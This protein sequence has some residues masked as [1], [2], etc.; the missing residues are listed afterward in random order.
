VKKLLRQAATAIAAL[1]VALCAA[2]DPSEG[3]APFPVLDAHVD[4][5]GRLLNRGDS[6]A[7]PDAGGQVDIPKWRTGGVNIVWVAIWVDPRRYPGEAAYEKANA[8]IDALEQDVRAH[9]KD[10]EL[11]RTAAQCQEAARRGKIALLLGLEGG[12]PLMSSP[13]V[14]DYFW[15]RGIRRVTL[16]WRGDLPW[17]GSSQNWDQSAVRRP[18]GLSELGEQLV[19]QMN[20]R[21]IVVDLSHT[22]ELTAR[23]AI[24]VSQ[25]PVIFSHSNCK[26][27]CDHPR[28]VSDDMLRA[29]RDNGGVIGVN[30][31]SRH[32][33]GNTL[34]AA[35][36]PR[37]AATI[38]DVVRHI[39]HIREVAGIDHIGI[40]SDWDGDITP[41]VG[42][43]DAS[44]L[45][46]L[47]EALRRHGYSEEDIRKIA[48][49]NF[50]RVI[51]A[52]KATN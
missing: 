8:L 7:D 12:E 42:L 43:E 45:P 47:W 30:F 14:L 32:L 1:C 21:G 24:A 16:T 39:D 13:A 33:V 35:V 48:G 18:K 51:T 15:R 2:A 40:G 6:L 27:L 52:N 20:Q 19:R 38:E 37:R 31:H 25:R 23:D 49:A 26:A 10:L 29:L 36:M 28:N 34:R 46:A 44:R 11:C 22:S 17:A 3:V 50:L 4:P 41:A 5:V 9:R